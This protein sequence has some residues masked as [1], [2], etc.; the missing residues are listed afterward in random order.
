MYVNTEVNY[1]SIIQVQVQ[2]IQN[3]SS[4]LSSLSHITNF[5]NFFYLNLTSHM[6]KQ[7]HTQ[8]NNDLSKV[9]LI[10]TLSLMSLGQIGPKVQG[11]DL[12]YIC[13]QVGKIR[14]PS[15]LVQKESHLYH[16]FLTPDFQTFHHIIPL[17]LQKRFTLKQKGLAT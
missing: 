16:C 5:N 9:N 13:T 17:N 1:F 4:L 6:I 12:Q 2:N 8:V 10:A 11:L 15:T 14:L 3:F 7:M